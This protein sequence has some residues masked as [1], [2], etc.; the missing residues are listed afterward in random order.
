MKKTLLYFACAGLLAFSS[1][2]D[3]LV[4]DSLSKRG[5]EYV[6]SDKEEINRALTAVY[7][8]MM[9]SSTYGQYLIARYALNTDVEFKTYS[10][11]IRATTGSDFACFDGTK[12]SGDISSTWS[13]A[14]EGIERANIFIKGVESSPLYKETDLDLMQQIGEAKC[15]RAMFYHDLVVGWGD[16]PFRTEQSFGSEDLNIGLTDRREILTWLINDLKSI[17][18]KMKYADMMT[19]TVE[20]ISK[21]FCY[22]LIARMAMTRGGYSL[23]P[24]KANAMATGTMQRPTD[25]L[26]YYKI[27]KNYA[28]SVIT[29]GRNT[30][31]KSFRQVFIDECNYITSANDDPFFEIPFLKKSSGEVFSGHLRDFG[32]HGR[33]AGRWRHG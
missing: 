19:Y 9:S 10:S 5:T 24:D 17:G 16:I 22:G 23:Y 21:N 27:A 28:D 15:I 4:V 31:S 32:G 20:R 1:C 33:G 3:Y 12:Y 18:P 2:K 8:S 26:D 11:N 14:Y 6:F 13:A 30:L 25:Y 29:S 7:A